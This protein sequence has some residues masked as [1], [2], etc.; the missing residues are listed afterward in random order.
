MSRRSSSSSAS[1]NVTNTTTTVN[2]FDQ[3]VAGGAGITLGSGV[4][5][6]TIDAV[7]EEVLEEILQFGADFAGELIGLGSELVDGI[8]T[9]ATSTFELA[10]T[11]IDRS[12]NDAEKIANNALIMA[13]VVMV[14][15]VIFAGN[16]VK[17]V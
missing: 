4:S 14:A 7:P 13:G 5:G 12:R 9:N 17:I 10:N 11:V 2:T 1:S 16:G 15:F 6:V 3:R 8:D